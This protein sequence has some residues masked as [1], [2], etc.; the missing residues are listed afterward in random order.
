M[1][2]KFDH[3]SY[4][5]SLTSLECPNCNAPLD[6]DGHS[7]TIK[8]P[9]CGT[10]ISIP[11][12]MRESK[13]GDTKAPAGFQ[14]VSS[15]G[16]DPSVME[17]IIR[18]I[19]DDKLIEAIRLYRETT[20]VGLKESK[21]TVESIRDGINAVKTTENNFSFTGTTYTQTFESAGKVAAVTSGAGLMTCLIIG[22]ILLFVGGILAFVFTRPDSPFRTTMGAMDPATLVQDADG[23]VTGVV[24]QVYDVNKELRKIIW[25][26]TEKNKTLWVSSSMSGDE[27]AGLLTVTPDLVYITVGS[28]LIA[29]HSTDG[30]TAWQTKLTDKAITYEENLFVMG[31]RVLV[32]SIDDHLHAFDAQTGSPAWARDIQAPSGSMQ[33]AGDHLLIWDYTEGDDYHPELVLLDPVDGSEDMTITPKCSRASDSSII[34]YLNNEDGVM[35]DNAGNTLYLV[36]GTFQGCVQAYELSTGALLWE[37]KNSDG[38]STSFYDFYSIDTGDRI[39]FGMYHGLGYID[40]NNQSWETIIENEDYYFTPL[41]LIKDMIITRVK[42]T[43]GSRYELW[44]IDTITGKVAWKYSLEENLPLDPPCIGSPT[45]DEDEYAWTWHA[46]PA[47][48]QLVKFQGEPN[49]MILS[50]LDPKTGKSLDEK[51]VS[52]EKAVTGRLPSVD[53]I[54]WQGNELWVIT[55]NKIV[56]VDT[57]AGKLLSVWQ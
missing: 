6:F 30:S 43:T 21:I 50:T 26:D 18:L 4:N 36:M 29:I 3:M 10:S 47:G 51:E 20:G 27:M 23:D 28:K 40:K 34:D 17:E 14:T 25:L 7:A 41:T 46:A 13:A 19:R 1:K 38:F 12:S 11:K 2:G 33:M 52:L 55:W 45:I 31:G 54:G 42:K 35:V 9:F 22:M 5:T 53:I 39:Y 48:F 56:S 15:T 8:C 24:S 37:Q 16:I 32:K 57:V 49:R 44:G